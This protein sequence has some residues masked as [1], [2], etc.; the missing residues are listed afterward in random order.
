MGL[1]PTTSTLRV[2]REAHCATPPRFMMDTVKWQ[3]P[4]VQPTA[5]YNDGD[6]DDDNDD[7]DDE[8]AKVVVS[9]TTTSIMLS[10]I[11]SLV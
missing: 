9:K 10:I 1:E 4:T 3:V 5:P 2:K 11:Y 7:D 6:D 8:E